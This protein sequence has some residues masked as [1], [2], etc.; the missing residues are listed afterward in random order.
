MT[1]PELERQP[2]HRVRQLDELR[3]PRLKTEA[4]QDDQG[5][6]SPPQKEVATRR[7]SGPTF[8]NSCCR[9]VLRDRTTRPQDT[10]QGVPNLGAVGAV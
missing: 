1:L 8:A 7:P 10:E 5:A 9:N 3:R 2:V 4:T 6:A